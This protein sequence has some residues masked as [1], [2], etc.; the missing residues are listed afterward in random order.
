MNNVFI[1]LS[2]NHATH[3]LLNVPH[4]VIDV[5]DLGGTRARTATIAIY[6]S[7]CKAGMS[8]AQSSTKHSLP[9]ITDPGSIV[10][11]CLETCREN[12]GI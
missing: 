7:R 5:A 11:I 9:R 8:D 4:C 2:D 6:D 12:S 10:Q 1:S 3:S